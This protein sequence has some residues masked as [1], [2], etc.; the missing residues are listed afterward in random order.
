MEVQRGNKDVETMCDGKVGSL[1]LFVH[2]CSQRSNFL[3]SPVR[4]LSFVGVLWD[5]GGWCVGALAR[6]KSE[7]LVDMLLL[8]IILFH[9]HS[10]LALFT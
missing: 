2:L 10:K 3:R 4:E 5:G 8:C 1:L 9:L 6:A 7:K